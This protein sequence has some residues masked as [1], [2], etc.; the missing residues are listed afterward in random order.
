M[1]TSL[2][3]AVLLPDVLGTYSDAGNAVVLAQRARRR[4][5]PADVHHVAVTDTPPHSA[6]IYLLGG[7]EDAAQLT[8]ARWLH[9]H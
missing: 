1:G 2:A 4:G 8:A 5:I 9:S 7:G 6:D 3:I